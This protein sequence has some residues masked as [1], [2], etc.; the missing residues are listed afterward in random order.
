MDFNQ[1]EMTNGTKYRVLV[2]YDELV[3]TVDTALK[4]GGLLTVPMG[5][6]KPGNMQTINPAQ[7]VAIDNLQNY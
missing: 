3:R 6:T 5:I 4:E 7:I 2:D 1:V